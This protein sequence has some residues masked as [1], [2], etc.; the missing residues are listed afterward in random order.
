MS[1]LSIQPVYPIFTDIDGQPLEAGYVWIGQ[2]NL[3]PQVNPINV[4]WD[5]ALTIPAGQPIRTLGGYPSRNGTP[6]RLYVNS[7]YSIRV[8]NKNGSV[9]YSAPA[10]TERYGNIITLTNLDFVQSGSGAVTRTALSKMREA[11]SVT[12]FGAIGD[13]VTDDRQAILD[14]LT[15]LPNG[16]TLMFPPGTYLVSAQINLPYGNVRLQGYDYNASVIKIANNY[17]DQTQLFR[18]DSVS[19]LTFA[20][21]GFDGNLE[22]QNVV[23]TADTKQIA[24]AIVGTS[25]D[26]TVQRCHF[27]DWGKDGVYVGTINNKRVMVSECRFQNIR[28]IG[29]TAV[30]GEQIHV[31]NNQF[32]EG[33]AQ[34]NAVFNNGVHY[35]ANSAADSL[36]G[37]VIVGNSFSNMQGGVMLYNSNGASCS[38]LIIE[39]NNFD[40]ITQRGAVVAYAL[41]TAG[42]T[43]QG[44][45]FRNCGQDATSSV[46]TNGCVDVNNTANAIITN[47][48]F[49]NC[50][51][52]FGTI[53]LAGTG[54]RGAQIKNNVFQS[55]QRR[56]IYLAYAFGSG[57]T[58]SLRQI[59]GN[60]MIGG[61]QEAANTYPAIEIANS[62]S[63]EGN[64][65]ILTGNSIQIST[66]S[67]YNT[68]ISIDRDSGISIVG[69][70]TIVGS[71]GTK[72]SFTNGTPTL[73][74][75]YSRD[76]AV[77][78]DPTS[79]ADGAGETIDVTVSGAV[80]G[81]QVLFSPGVNVQGILV[82]ATVRNTNTVQ[83]RLQNETGGT[84]DLS[85][86]TWKFKT[87]RPII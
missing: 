6:A 44:N 62:A 43:I 31:I 18:C 10:A 66:T 19:M 38:G 22:N 54:S 75:D 34:T 21:L 39:G 3:D 63:H 20:D 25:C 74:W 29:V 2:A 17:T 47:N 40:T 23:S 83:L 45:K 7:D 37:F 36:R 33:S 46:E 49:E 48:S 58:G 24:I 32:Y 67:G 52:F 9:V 35:E 71:T 41:G 85:S 84:L 15:S 61:G 86:S 64:G 60:V 59:T 57:S 4:Y 1:A 78:V 73:L 51:G 87:I 82:T 53:A 16:G 72:Y 12:D 55:D 13:G 76:V 27:K 30:A 11:V 70:N 68:G 69:Q 79:L 50:T 26:V 14:A 81:D 56:G 42:V 8:M 80:V 28:R 5:A 65:D 77:T